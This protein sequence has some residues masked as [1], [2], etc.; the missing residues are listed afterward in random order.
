MIYLMGTGAFSMDQLRKLTVAEF[1][2]LAVADTM[3]TTLEL[4]DACDEI[5]HGRADEERAFV[6][7]SGRPYS[8]NDLTKMLK[9]AH[10][11]AG[12][13]YDGWLAFVEAV[14]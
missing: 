13:P 11:I 1:K 9:R 14:H 4:Q 10:Q 2:S 8:A 3:P 5:A 6:N 12:V 7:T